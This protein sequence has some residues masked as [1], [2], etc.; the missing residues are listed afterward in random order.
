[1][2]GSRSLVCGEARTRILH[3]FLYDEVA[4]SHPTSDRSVFPVGTSLLI[5]FALRG[6]LTEWSRCC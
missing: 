6:H 2:R 3:L 4:R 1:M 5:R